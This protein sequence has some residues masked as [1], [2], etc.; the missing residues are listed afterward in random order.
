M[1]RLIPDLFCPHLLP[2]PQRRIVRQV[3]YVGSFCLSNMI[4]AAQYTKR[5]SLPTSMLS[6]AQLVKDTHGCLRQVFRFV[7]W[8]KFDWDLEPPFHHDNSSLADGHG[9]KYFLGCI[10][11]NQMSSLILH[12]PQQLLHGN[13]LL[14]DVHCVCNHDSYLPNKSS[15]YHGPIF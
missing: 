9:R 3:L 13:I 14:G 10:Q 12:I 5:L 11:G 8:R 2:I 15:G 7:I 4:P 6:G 1:V